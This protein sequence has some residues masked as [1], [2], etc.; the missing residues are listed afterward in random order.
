M[1]YCLTRIKQTL[2][3]QNYSDRTNIKMKT[4]RKEKEDDIIFDKPIINTEDFPEIMWKK[5]S[6]DQFV[7]KQIISVAIMVSISTTQEEIEEEALNTWNEICRSRHIVNSNIVKAFE[8][9]QLL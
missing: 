8:W 9:Q 1:P 3:L 7:R 6:T 4:Y 2:K 5:I